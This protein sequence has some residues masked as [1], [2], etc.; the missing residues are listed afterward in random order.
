M[1]YPDIHVLHCP[2]CSETIVPTW[3]C[4][5]TSGTYRCVEQ[6]GHEGWHWADPGS[7]GEIIRWTGLHVTRGC[8]GHLDLRAWCQKKPGHDRG[9]NVNGITFSD[10]IEEDEPE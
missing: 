5:S 7:P 3:R 6:Q 9:H 4:V 1:N 8:Y 10:P 2:R